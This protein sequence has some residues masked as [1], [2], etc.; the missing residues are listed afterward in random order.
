MTR[1]LAPIVVPILLIFVNT[2]ISALELEG[3][4]YDYL[5]F[6]WDSPSSPSA[7]DF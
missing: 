2:T 6:V 3:G 1:S 5:M 7:W 4:I